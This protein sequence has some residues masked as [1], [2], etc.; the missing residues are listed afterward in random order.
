MSIHLTAAQVQQFDS[1]VKHA[2]QGMGMLRPTVRVKT[3]V[4]GNQHKFPTMGKG[5][6]TARVPQTDVVPMNISHARVAATLADWNAPEYTDIF[7]QQKV[8]YEEK[9]QLATVIAGAIGRREDQIIIDVI[10]AGAALTAV[11]ENIG[12]T[13]TNLNTAKMREAKQKMDAKG[14]SQADRHAAIHANNLYGLLGDP[15]ANTF[16]KNAIKALVD[17]E[18]TKWLGFNIKVIEDRDEGGLTLSSNERS[19]LFYHGGSMGSTGLAVG[20]D[21]R[22]EIN[23]IAEKTS[24]LCNGLF[25]AGA[26]AIEGNGAVKVQCYEA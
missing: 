22:T 3:G 26:A 21:F 14:V 5:M 10:E 25:S 6:A 1:D 15:D 18:I 9:Q 17:G 16:D 7:D 11:D 24:W 8:N 4:V 23:Y 2:Y 20:I 12:G 13:D 19:T